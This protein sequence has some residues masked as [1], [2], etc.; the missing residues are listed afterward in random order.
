MGLSLFAT[1]NIYGSGE[2]FSPEKFRSVIRNTCKDLVGKELEAAPS[3]NGSHGESIFRKHGMSGARGEAE[4]GLQTVFD[5]GLP[6]LTGSSGLNDDAMSRCFLSIAAHCQDTNI[7]Y[8][9]SPEVLKGFQDL[10]AR[11][12]E[13]MNPDSLSAVIEYCREKNIS[14]GGSADLLAVSIFVWLVMDADKRQKIPSLF[15]KNDF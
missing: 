7:L 2:N 12:A 15:Q 8:R 9:S 6:R 3:S 13:E 5:H 4:S 10:C 1:G 11:A 14:P